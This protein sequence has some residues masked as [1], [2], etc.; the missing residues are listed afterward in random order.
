MQLCNVI[1]IV[2]V[3]TRKLCLFITSK[4]QANFYIVVQNVQ[5]KGVALPCHAWLIR[6]IQRIC[7]TWKFFCLGQVKKIA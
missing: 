7:Q 2:V 3:L 6:R 1:D 5:I 4:V